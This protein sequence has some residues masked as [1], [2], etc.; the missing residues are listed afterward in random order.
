MDVIATVRD[1]CTHSATRLALSQLHSSLQ[2]L[3]G[4]AEL[5]ALRRQLDVACSMDPASHWLCKDDHSP[6]SVGGAECGERS[7]EHRQCDAG[8]IEQA[9]AIQAFAQSSPTVKSWMTRALRVGRR[10]GVR[11]L[12]TGC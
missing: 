10:S 1:D 2:S 7:S 12:R 4:E 6:H 5:S 11:R 3:R 9:T 8:S